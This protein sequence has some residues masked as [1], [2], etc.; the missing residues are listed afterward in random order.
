MPLPKPPKA[1]IIYEDSR[2][3]ACLAMRPITRGHTVVAWK[4]PVRDLHLLSCAEVEHLMDV[5]DLVRDALLDAL[6]IEKVYL[7][8]MDDAKHVHWHL[9]PRYNEHGF[10]VFASAPKRVHAFPFAPQ[11]RAAITRATE[12]H[13]EFRGKLAHRVRGHAQIRP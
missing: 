3:Y 12:H 6:K 10:D 2:V 9:V 8:Y 13:R 4:R 11:L 1:S 5:I 7:I